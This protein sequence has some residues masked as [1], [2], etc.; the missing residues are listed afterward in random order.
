MNTENNSPI[1]TR[2]TRDADIDEIYSIYMHESVSPYLAFDVCS[3][4]EFLRIFEALRNN[5]ELIVFEGESG[6]VGVCKI[7]RRDH[8]LRHSAYIGSLAV[9]ADLQGRGLGRRIMVTVL[10]QLEAEGIKRIE[11]LVACD[12]AKTID[13]FISLGFVIEGTMKDYFSR[14]KTTGFFDE[15]IM[16][17][18]ID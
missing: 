1:T 15:H 11:V 14:E 2:L 6:I 5:G 9:K 3:R 12:N 17:L 13:F 16:G 7:S 10:S 4:V 8:R 18:L